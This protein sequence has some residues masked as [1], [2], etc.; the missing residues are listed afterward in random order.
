MEEHHLAVRAV[1]LRSLPFEVLRKQKRHMRRHMRKPREM[2][3]KTYVGHMIKINQD[4]LPQ[5]P[6]FAANQSI[7]QDEMAEIIHSGLP[8]SWQ[9]E[10]TKLSFVPEEHN[11]TEMTAFC[12]R[13]EETEGT[14]EKAKHHSPSQESRTHKKHKGGSNGPNDTVSGAKPYCT[15]H[16][17]H[18]HSTED[19]RQKNYHGQQKSGGNYK[20]KSWKR[21]ADNGRTY[22]KNEVATLMQKAVDKD[23]KG[24]ERKVYKRKP[25]VAFADLIEEIEYQK[26]ESE[27]EEEEINELTLAPNN[28]YVDYMSLEKL[29]DEIDEIDKQIEAIPDAPL[30]TGDIIEDEQ[31]ALKMAQQME[32]IDNRLAEFQKDEAIRR[33]FEAPSDKELEFE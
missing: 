28:N 2:R 3:M 7:P 12:E 30:N 14:Q 19:C 8:T 20:N 25:E 10:M 11:L 26:D 15:Y 13:L 24:P 5:L 21:Q 18:T 27:V 17:S 29:Q 6:P 16:K 22:T 9:H 33:A 32:D 31:E 4:E 23:R 1:V